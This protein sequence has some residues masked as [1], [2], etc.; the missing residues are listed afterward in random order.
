MAGRILPLWICCLGAL[1]WPD[2]HTDEEVA[3][4]ELAG[5]EAGIPKP[6]AELPKHVPAQAG[7]LTLF[8]DFA[9]AGKNKMPDDERGPWPDERR[10]DSRVPLYL[11]NRTEQAV[12]LPFQDGD[13]KLRLEYRKAKGEWV[14]AQPQYASWCGNSYY[15]RELKPGQYLVMTGLM[16]RNVWLCRILPGRLRLALDLSLG[17]SPSR[18]RSWITTGPKSMR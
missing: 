1:A 11:V 15:S 14:R 9:A 16:E 13:A 12:S 4:A 5:V 18:V 7:K 10:P 8:A 6:N 17:G 3:R 2:R